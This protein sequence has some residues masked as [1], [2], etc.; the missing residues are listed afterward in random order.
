M[1]LLDSHVLLWL[2]NEPELLSKA[3]ASE[4]HQ[5]ELKRQPICISSAT[6]YELSYS[7]RRGRIRLNISTGYFLSLLF[8]RCRVITVN[9]DIAY[10]A[11][12]LPDTIPSDPMDRLIVATALVEDVP[13]ITADKKI[14]A[15]FVC[16]TCW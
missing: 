16:K 1:I 6:L 7:M 10:S 2:L 12:M 5:A 4:I 9:A 3:A 15:S 8:N 14:L 13:L 11:A